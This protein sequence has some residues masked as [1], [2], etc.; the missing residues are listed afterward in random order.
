MGNWLEDTF[1]EV[2]RQDRVVCKDVTGLS[3]EELKALPATISD[4]HD[5]EDETQDDKE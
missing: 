5:T 1:T 3:T 2:E 4:P